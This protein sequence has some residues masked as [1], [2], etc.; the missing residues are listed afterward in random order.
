MLSLTIRKPRTIL[1]MVGSILLILAGLWHWQSQAAST[2]T[3]ASSSSPAPVPVEV[4]SA[5]AADVPVYLEGLG[6]VQAFN[7]VTV[8]TRVDGQIQ[9]VSFVE[10]QQ[11]KTGDLLVQIDPR[12]YQASYDQMVAKKAQD[13]AQLA[14]AKVDLDRYT[15]LLK[16]NAINRQQA[17]TQ[18]AL[19]AQLEAAVRAD[20]GAIEA[21]K[22]QLDYTGIT[23]PIG[24][25]TGIRLVD[26]G[27]IVHATD[28]T[29]IVVVTQLQPISVVFTLPEDDLQSVSQAMAQGPV[30]VAALSRDGKTELDRGSLL[31]IDNQIDQTTG[32]I[33]LK[34]TF[35]NPRNALWPGQFVNV[36]L[37]L[38]TEHNVLTVPSAAIERGPNG[39]FTYVV[40]PDS[41]L[42]TR[43]VTVAHDAGAVS[44]IASGL[45]HGERVVTAGQYRVQPGAVVQVGTANSQPAAATQQ[46]A[47]QP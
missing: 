17:D 29:G 46:V 4:A 41:T 22:V 44:V 28:T 42:D 25:I 30:A 21:A 37:L 34:A 14:N 8:K 16:T 45:A 13:E 5:S 2:A 47:A 1:L 35:P 39:L 18:R 6:T 32:T 36:R 20:D 31:L 7:T 26:Q 43:T 24:G 9:R 27:N 12:P 15:A 33:R 23:S 11:V 10:G 19:V 3:S 38:Q 40:K